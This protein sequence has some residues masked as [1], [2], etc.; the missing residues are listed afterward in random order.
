[1]LWL[2]S[3]AASVICGF[4]CR[5]LLVVCRF[6]TVLPLILCWR[7]CPV[8]KKQGL[9]VPS[10][11]CSCPF[12]VVSGYFAVWAALVLVSV[13]SILLKDRNWGWL[14]CGCSHVGLQ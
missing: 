12:A 5:F 7:L 1:M 4:C 14:G 13:G 9:V 11:I 8:G 10:R 6:R 3:L 2:F